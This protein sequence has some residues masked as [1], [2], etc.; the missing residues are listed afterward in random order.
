MCK[1]HSALGRVSQIGALPCGHVLALHGLHRS[2]D[3]GYYAPF[4]P[5]CAGEVLSDGGRGEGKEIQ[6]SCSSSFLQIL[7]LAVGIVELR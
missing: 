5:D 3:V 4:L 2:D 7:M 6:R 1:K